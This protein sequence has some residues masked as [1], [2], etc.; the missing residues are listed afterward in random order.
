MVAAVVKV[1]TVVVVVLLILIIIPLVGPFVTKQMP[2]VAEWTGNILEA[3]WA[4]FQKLLQ[5]F[6]FSGHY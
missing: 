1:L 6:G 5:G 4:G 3:T 2:Q